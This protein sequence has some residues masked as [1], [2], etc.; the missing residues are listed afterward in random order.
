MVEWSVERRW[1]PGIACH[2]SLSTSDRGESIRSFPGVT[3][4][5]AASQSPSSERSRHVIRLSIRCR[6]AGPCAIHV[7]LLLSSLSLLLRK[8]SCTQGHTQPQSMSNARLPSQSHF[9]WWSFDRCLTNCTCNIC[10]QSRRPY[11]EMLEFL[12]SL[13]SQQITLGD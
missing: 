9:A 7:P 2:V 1:L 8:S 12:L 11:R 3:T 5:L 10:Q 4:H 13:F 6:L